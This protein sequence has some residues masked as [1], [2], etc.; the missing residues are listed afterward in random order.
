[1][2]DEKIGIEKEKEIVYIFF[3][4]IKKAQLIEWENYGKY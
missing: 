3:N 4:E 2:N 1:V